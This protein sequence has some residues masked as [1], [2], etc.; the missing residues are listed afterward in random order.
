MIA[1]AKTSSSGFGP[2]SA[3]SGASP[4]PPEGVSGTGNTPS[5]TPFWKRIFQSVL[6]HAG[7]FLAPKTA[8]SLDCAF[9]GLDNM[10]K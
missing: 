4:L 2:H 6:Y 7:A 5:E 9:K 1:R 10:F 8:K 3:P